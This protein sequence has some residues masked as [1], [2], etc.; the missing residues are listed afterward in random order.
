MKDAPEGRVDTKSMPPSGQF[1]P[2]SHAP[3]SIT[4]STE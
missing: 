3:I 1:Y 2:V 4:R